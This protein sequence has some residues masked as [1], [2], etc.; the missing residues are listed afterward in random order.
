[1]R[2]IQYIVYSG[3]SFFQCKVGILWCCSFTSNVIYLVHPKN[4]MMENRINW[5]LYFL[6]KIN[7]NKYYESSEVEKNKEHNFS[8]PSWHAKRVLA[9]KTKVCEITKH[10]ASKQTLIYYFYGAETNY[11]I[12][13]NDLPEVRLG[14]CRVL[15]GGKSLVANMR[16]NT[17]SSS[18]SLSQ[19]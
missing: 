11:Q 12:S 5:L 8:K 3:I 19:R 4:T 9:E 13:I 16:L 7:I 10:S 15:C 14:K 18:S 6:W 2:N 1:M 17:I